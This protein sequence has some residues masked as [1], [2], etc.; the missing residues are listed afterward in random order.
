MAPVRGG[1]L[2]Q[3]NLEVFLIVEFLVFFEEREMASTGRPPRST[4]SYWLLRLVHAD[5]SGFWLVVGLV[6]QLL[7]VIGD[8]FVAGNF[9]DS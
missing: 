1:G 9:Q 4:F 3:V 5:Q 6:G 2:T 8:G 7:T